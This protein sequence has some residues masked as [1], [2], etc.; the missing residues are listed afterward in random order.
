M[1]TFFKFFFICLLIAVPAYW[2][3]DSQQEGYTFASE[4]IYFLLFE[5]GVAAIFAY[6]LWRDARP[7]LNKR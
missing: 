3:H 1:K 6:A 7:N 5:I 2:Y 4:G